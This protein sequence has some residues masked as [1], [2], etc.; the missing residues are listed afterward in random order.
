MT[1]NPDT[2]TLDVA[3]VGALYAVLAY[4][5]WGL[6]PIFWKFFQGIPAMEVVAHRMLW[7]LLF[8]VGLI[9]FQRRLPE[10][11]AILR[12]PRQLLVLLLTA[13][14]LTANWGIYVYGINSDQVVETS[15]GYFINPLINVLLGFIFLRE[16]FNRWQTFAVL[17]AILGVGNFV[18][19]LGTWPW[20][21]LGLGFSFSVY[22]LLRKLAPAPPLIGLAIETLLLAPVAALAIFWWAQQGVGT[23][24]HSTTQDLLFLLA[25]VVTSLP[26][27]WFANAGKRLRFSTLGLF[28]YL[29]PTLQFLLGVFVYGEPFTSAHALTFALIWTALFLYSGNTLWQRRRVSPP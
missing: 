8:V 15:L 10:L 27:L 28:Q 21:A 9:A 11:R 3:H 20:I 6:L 26:L 29:A 12:A 4:G 16:R 22:G 7:S 1:A 19:S 14:L 24:G 5:F 25:G 2:K 23:F 18:W 13:L 17:L